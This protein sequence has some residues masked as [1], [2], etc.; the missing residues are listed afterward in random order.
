MVGLNLE[1]T[2]IMEW[3]MFLEDQIFQI[4][5]TLSHTLSGKKCHKV[6]ISLYYYIYFIKIFF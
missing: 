6:F 1:L 3:L 2:T 5:M 4:M